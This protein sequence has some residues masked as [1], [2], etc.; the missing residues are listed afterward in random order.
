VDIDANLVLKNGRLFVATYQ[1]QVSA[2]DPNTGRILWQKSNS[3]YAD[4]TADEHALYAV[5][6]D[7]TITAYDQTSGRILWQQKDLAWRFLTGPTLY[8]HFLVVGDL[9]GYAHFINPE[10]GKLLGRIPID[11]RPTAIINT[12][13]ILDQSLIFINTEGRLVSIEA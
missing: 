8:H 5:T 13:Q 11:R 7:G 3:V 1:G 10:N 4:I 6:A 9:Q 2:L 12:P